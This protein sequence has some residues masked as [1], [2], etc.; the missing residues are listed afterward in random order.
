MKAAQVGSDMLAWFGLFA[1]LWP[2]DVHAEWSPA[3]SVVDG[4]MLVGQV[5][6]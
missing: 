3:T 2:R 4:S 6:A 1:P 5:S